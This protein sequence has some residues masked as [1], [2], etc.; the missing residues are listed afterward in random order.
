MR[1]RWLVNKKLKNYRS[2]DK[3]APDKDK[4]ATVLANNTLF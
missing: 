2:C 4:A 1:P 3:I